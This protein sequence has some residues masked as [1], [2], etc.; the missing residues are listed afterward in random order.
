MW[1]IWLI[2][3]GVL[4]FIVGF[5]FLMHALCMYKTVL[6]I[7]FGA[8][9]LA[10]GLYFLVRAL[11]IYK[12]EGKAKR[13]FSAIHVFTGG[14]F[15]SVVLVFIP[16]YYTY[17]DFGD[18]HGVF[19][20]LLI[21]IHNSLRVFI[22]DGEFDVVVDAIEKEPEVLRVCFSLYSAF[23]YVIAPILTFGNVLSLFKNV[24]GE[25]RY[26]WNKRKKHYI[27]SELNEKSI[28]LAKSICA[29]QHDAVIVFTDVF[30][31]NEEDDYEL[32]MQARDI[33]A[34]LL[35]KD[36]T[37][38]DFF[39]KKGDVEIFLIG[40]DESENVSQAVKITKDLDQRNAKH[41]DKKKEKHNVKVFVFSS[42]QSATYIID[43]VKYDNLLKYAGERDYGEDCF[44]LRRI[45]EKQQLI[46]NTVPKMNL[47]D[48][49]T[50]GDRIIS[51]LIVGFGSYGMEFFKML[52]W[53]CQFE[54]CKLQ[55]NIVDKRGKNEAG[56][57]EIKSLIDRACPE[58]L[59]KNRSAP[60][61]AQ[62]DIEIFSG[63]DALTSDIDELI[64]GAPHAA[65]RIRATD[66]AFVSLGDDDA[67]IEV[68]IHLRSLFDR[69]NGIC[70]K[71]NIGWKDEAVEIYSVVYDDQ[72]SG[73]LHHEDMTDT[74]AHLLHNHEGVPYHIHFIG[75]MSSQFDYRNIYN[76]ELEKCAYRHHIGWVDVEEK[77]Y[78]ASKNPESVKKLKGI[79]YCKTE[80]FQQNEKRK[81]EKFE[82]YRRS[83]IAKELYQ[84]AI[85]SNPL[86]V[87]QTVCL[88]AK[89]QT[90]ECENCVRR[91]K[92]EHM[93]WNAY[94]R[95]IGYTYNEGLKMTRARLHNNLC[96]WEKLTDDD[97]KK[98]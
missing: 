37:H 18:T 31:Q 21:A 87:A 51:V 47:Y 49:A 67:N 3:F 56:K 77:I 46:W 72:K 86:F 91:K 90:C 32:L 82:Y 83:S 70:A 74:E 26:K 60:G 23:L 27:M 7:V 98:D 24:K 84:R 1:T 81:Y 42:E 30:E 95:V 9:S 55:I 8:L 10:V 4:S 16:I 5:C 69:V 20:P 78:K 85:N 34:I 17:Y 39:K 33:N 62:Y 80:E 88:K 73:I 36:I 19:R 71:K 54:G 28:A 93:R 63:V 79:E 41:S 64:L 15:A 53:Y 40:N 94:T 45:D 6:L 29:R 52:V 76:A 75:G 25:M 14:V 92:S 68:S 13:V 11:C 48:L 65:K 58:L 89:L 22:L 44:K 38:V 43:S 57:D 61:D 59:K 97:K 50:R 35:K 96:V 2:V 66:L 12:N